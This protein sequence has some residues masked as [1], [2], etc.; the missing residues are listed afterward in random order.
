MGGTICQGFIQ[1]KLRETFENQIIQDA[2]TPHPDDKADVTAILAKDYA[3]WNDHDV[4]FLL[5]L[6]KELYFHY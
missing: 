1:M 4:R 5:K 3:Q 2:L 6:Q